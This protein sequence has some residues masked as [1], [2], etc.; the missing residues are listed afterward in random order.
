MATTGF[1]TS[2]LDDA[3]LR[4]NLRGVFNFGLERETLWQKSGF[5]EDSTEKPFE[6]YSSV[7]G[8]GYAERKNEFEAPIM[9][10]PKQ[11]YTKRVNVVAYAKVTGI[12]AEAKRFIQRGSIP[13]RE[14]FKLPKM[15]LNSL[16]AL[17]DVMA[18]DVFGNAFSSTLGLGPDGQPLCSASHVLGRGGTG[19]NTLEAVSLSQASLEAAII[20]S[21]R[22]TDEAGI[23][24]GLPAGSAQMLLLPP[25][26]GF[27]ADR[28]INSALQSD[29]AN[30]AKNT[31]KGRF[32]VQTNRMLPSSTNWFIVNKGVDDSLIA[33]FETKPKL[34]EFSDDKVGAMYFQ[35][36]QMCAFD[37]FNWRG[38]QG[39]S[40]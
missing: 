12:S 28:I 27:E 15:V 16:N 1:T 11:N 10:V 2:G 22:F 23:P 30:N 8:L 13:M 40:V 38:V 3:A 17:N 7:S 24:V 36:Y 35:A 32:T 20:Q 5:K 18:T 21:D 34:N 9:D 33:L 31:L 37:W 14:V 6:E 19:S 4:A 26:L 29:T 39:S 25:D